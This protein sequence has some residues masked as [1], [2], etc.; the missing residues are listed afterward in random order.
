MKVYIIDYTPK[1]ESNRYVTGVD[2][3]R[4]EN[5]L[6]VILYNVARISEMMEERCHIASFGHYRILLQ[7][8]CEKLV[9]VK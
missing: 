7:N 8:I 2:T 5:N 6:P 1:P 4:Y 3:V 9:D